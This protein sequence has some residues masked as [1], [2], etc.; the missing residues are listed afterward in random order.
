M[1]T[2]GT[3]TDTVVTTCLGGVAFVDPVI[4]EAVTRPL[5]VSAW[6]PAGGA[7]NAAHSANLQANRRGAYVLHRWRGQDTRHLWGD[8]PIAERVRSNF[9][10]RVA[11]PARIFLPMKFTLQLPAWTAPDLADSSNP[12]SVPAC[13]GLGAGQPIPLFSAPGRNAPAGC[14]AIRGRV[15]AREKIEAPARWALL[16]VFRASDPVATR[17]PLARAMADA[18]G[19]FCL[20]F[21]QPAADAPPAAS[22]H[23]KPV[24]KIVLE[25]RFDEAN[26]DEPQVGGDA[27]AKVFDYCKVVAQPVRDVIVIPDLAD[28]ANDV[29][30]ATQSIEPGVDLVLPVPASP[31]SPHDNLYL[32]IR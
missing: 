15:F 20:L 3:R 13:D 32:K 18:E 25:A 11:D 29:P 30:L 24:V 5:A 6:L 26:L 27:R 28:D 12:L 23:D 16:R 31:D 1:N 14:Q 9:E 8:K 4:G 21:A 22:P 19:R 10:I 17:K 2:P 7:E